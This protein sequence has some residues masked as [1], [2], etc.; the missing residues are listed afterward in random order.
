M[1]FVRWIGVIVLVLGVVSLAF[2]ILFIVNASSGES[3]IADG[4]KP[5]LTIEE[6]NSRFDAVKPL[7]TAMA[8]AEL[9]NIQ[10]GQ[11]PS[12][13]YNYLTITTTS[14]GLTKA[15]I[16]LVSFT[17]TLGILNV[18][19]GIGLASAGLGLLKVKP[20]AT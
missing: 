13:M 18:V 11:D 4:L 2:G 20:K 15:Q 1:G 3:Q 6:V 12:A 7:Q 17:R 19:I 16:G 10:A 9:P 8:Q 14:L 5:F